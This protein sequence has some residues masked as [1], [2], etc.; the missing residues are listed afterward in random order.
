MAK[1][2]REG[3]RNLLETASTA[4]VRYDEEKP[5]LRLRPICNIAQLLPRTIKK[6]KNNDQKPTFSCMVL[7]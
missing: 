6:L 4:R 2:G 1:R 3:R 5:G 7:H